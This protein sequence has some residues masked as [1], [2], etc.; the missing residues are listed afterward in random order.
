MSGSAPVALLAAAAG[1][2]LAAAARE[3]VTVTPALA[4]WVRLA[5]EPLRRAAREGYRPT[6]PERRRLAAV[7][8]AALLGAGTVFVGPGG[9]PL[10][11]LAAPAAVATTLRRRRA[12]YLRAVELGLG[13]VAVSIADALAGG[14]SLRAA[15]GEA[16]TGCEG[17]AG[18]ELARVG[19][20]LELG[21]S[22]P[23]AIAELAGRVRS[24][25][26]DSFCAA[27]LSQRVAGGDLS[28][29]MRT[30]A[31]AAAERDRA[32]AA[33]RAATAQAR[34]TGILVA[35][36]PVGAAL[37]A[38]LL[39]PSFVAGLLAEPASA[40]LLALAAG[41]QLGGFMAIARLSRVETT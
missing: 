21:R 27:L 11:G 38:E 37:F 35:A 25:R 2:L 13:E 26:V 19:A 36:M 33:A 20:D 28:G 23:K 16:A 4:G 7:G 1:G 18:V 29:L 14:R 8:A 30:F 22:T 34:F 6:G 10:L 17:P 15:I 39:E 5:L 24:A 3:I 41:L 9:A 32:L 31:S 40:L 12:R